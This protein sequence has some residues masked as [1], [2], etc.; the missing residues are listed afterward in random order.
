[1]DKRTP[2]QFLKEEGM[3]IETAKRIFRNIVGFINRNPDLGCSKDIP[4]I[5]IIMECITA[6]TLHAGGSSARQLL[7]DIDEDPWG[8]SEL[9]YCD[10]EL[11]DFLGCCMRCE[12]E[13]YKKAKKEEEENNG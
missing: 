8:C 13:K 12:C 5:K 4:N 9:K 11:C 3:T 10:I 1:M 6:G 2:E 7:T